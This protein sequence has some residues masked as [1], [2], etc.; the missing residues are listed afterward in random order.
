M[1]PENEKF[2]RPFLG[3]VNG[4][5]IGLKLNGIPLHQSLRKTMVLG[6]LATITSVI[7]I[8]DEFVTTKYI[9]D[10]S[11]YRLSQDHIELTFNVVRFRG[12]WKNN[13]TACQ[14]QAAYRQLLI[15]NDI[16]PQ[17]T[18]NAVV[19]EDVTFGDQLQ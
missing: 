15:K 11:T 6:F 17:N 13:P 14:F 5:L 9:S 4:Y 12:R 2:W 19:Q 16:K 1:K 10:L 7:S 18:G 8:Y 3:K